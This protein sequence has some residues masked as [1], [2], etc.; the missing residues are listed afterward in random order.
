MSNITKSNRSF[1]DF[2]EEIENYTK[3]LGGGLNMPFYRGC[4]ESTHTLIPSLFRNESKIKN[5]LSLELLENNYFY[6]F[7][8]HSEG[9]QTDNNDWSVLFR[10]QHFGFPTRLL[11]W[12]ENFAV[13]LYFALKFSSHYNSPCIWILDP[14]RLNN[15]KNEIPKIK[16]T[17]IKDETLYNP[18]RDFIYSYYDAFIVNNLKENQSVF[19]FPKALYPIKSNERIRAQKGVFTIHGNQR[20]CISKLAPKCVKKF[21]IPESA[22]PSAL[23]F[24]KQFSVTHFSMFPDFEGLKKQLQE[25]YYL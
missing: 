9:I 11:D 15:L 7:T 6:D 4:N 23:N 25:E 1:L 14:Y 10:M 19:D 22:I 24:L 8:S 3:R 5:N 20:E 21:T 2:F 13:A 18:N 17:N 12:S 16:F